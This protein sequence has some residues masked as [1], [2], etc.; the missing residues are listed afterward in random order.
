MTRQSYERC[1]RCH[2]PHG[3]NPLCVVV[4]APGDGARGR[5]GTGIR[6]VLIGASIEFALAVD[7]PKMPNADCF[8]AALERW[9]DVQ[10]GSTDTSASQ[11]GVSWCDSQSE[12]HSLLSLTELQ[13]PRGPGDPRTSRRFGEC[14]NPDL[15]SQQDVRNSKSAQPCYLN[16]TLCSSMAPVASLPIEIMF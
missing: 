11:V 1:G 5:R 9:L 15:C 2:L 16:G 8:G 13:T 7:P 10:G 4:G 6:M 12:Y 3:V 14:S